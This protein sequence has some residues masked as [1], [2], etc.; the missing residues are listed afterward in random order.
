MLQ[1]IRA[2]D[3]ADMS[4]KA[5]NIMAAQIT[6]KKDSVL[7]LATG[8]TP[9][10][11]YRCLIEKYNQGDLDFSQVR[12]VNL[13]EYLGLEKEHDQSYYYFM[14]ENLF[15]HV[16]IP[17][18]ATH[19][20][21]GTNADAEAECK[22][23]HDLIMGMGGIDIQL[24]GIGNNGH[25]GFNEPSDVFEECV[26]CVELTESTIQANARFFASEAEVP[27]RAITMGI[28]EIMAAKTVLV[29]ASGKAKAE[30]VKGLI[31]GPI[32]PQLQASALRLHPNAIL[33]ADEDALSLV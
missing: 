8:S 2:K 18:D 17:A 11:L 33:V 23:Y 24:L 32:T 10:G 25:I 15:K 21:D 31:S 5:A 4:R 6:L 30:A 13:D 27:R 28:G 22:R 20:P 26:H 14:Y 9:I 19:L 7:G 1:V 3:Y 29:V 16:N 12:S